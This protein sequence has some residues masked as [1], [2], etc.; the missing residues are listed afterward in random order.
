MSSSSLDNDTGLSSPQFSEKK[1]RTIGK[2]DETILIVDDD[3]LIR[4][5]L[6]QS[7]TQAGFEIIVAKD[8]DHA[9]H[10]MKS[11]RVAAIVCDQKMPGMAGLEVL[12][13][14]AEIEPDVVR[15]L[16]TASPDSGVAIRAVNEGKVYQFIEKPWDEALLIQTMKGAVRQYKLVHENKTL[17]TLLLEKHNALTQSLKNLHQEIKMAS[18]IH[19]TLLVGSVP[20]GI[21]GMSIEA[22]TVPSK[23]IDGDFFDFFNQGGRVFDIAVGDVMGKGI[24][25]SVVGT[26]VKTQLL[27]FANPVS[28]LYGDSEKA[29]MRLTPQEIVFKLS[30]EIADKLMRLEYFVCLIYGRFDLDRQIFSFVDCGT[31]GP[32]HFSHA[33]Q[34]AKYAEC[35]NYPIGIVSPK[36]YAYNELSFAPNDLF[37][38]CSD[39]VTEARSPEGEVFGSSRLLEIVENSARLEPKDLIELIQD[40][41]LSFAQKDHYDDD[42]SLIVVR[43]DEGIEEGKIAKEI[44]FSSRLEEL[45]RLRCCLR[46][47]LREWNYSDEEFALKL[48]LVANEV[49]CNIVEHG[50]SFKENGKIFVDIRKEKGGVCMEF[51]DKGDSLEPSRLIHAELSPEK[52]QGFGLYII[53]TV[54]DLVEYQCKNSKQKWNRLKVL[55]T[56]PS[57]G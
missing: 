4:S 27:R 34:R 35:K 44:S 45:G 41:V 40:T 57:G 26:A 38:F 30:H 55:K 53:K 16:M 43:I 33:L 18:I 7:L 13:T 5:L 21:N 11:V 39:G 47:R 24:T 54:C 15:V 12:K 3:P 8:G 1:R 36:K 56:Y 10:L 2:G 52:S 6:E 29:P 25:A 42:L 31:P 48:E 50:Y 17:Q 37:V 28:A 20:K 14:V 22:V 32:I 51:F 9:L 46:E 49:F 23:G 19:E